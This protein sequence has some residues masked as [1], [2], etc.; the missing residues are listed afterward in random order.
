MSLNTLL[1]AVDC[2]S[3]WVGKTV[4]WLCLA[5]ILVLLYEVTSRYIAN[6]PTEWAHE[7][8]TM[9]YGTFCILGAVWTLRERGH[10]RTEVVYQVMSQKL[11]NFCDIVTGLV[12]LVMLVIFFYVAFEF[13]L[14]SWKSKEVSSKSTWGVIIY[15]F[16]TVIP[17]A[18]AL[19][20]LQQLSHMIR[21]VMRFIGRPTETLSVDTQD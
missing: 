18:V 7:S 3:E 11:Q 14:E 17:V 12:V 15:P 8:T 6:S 21:D 13:A 10:V 1:N 2:F 16:K 20:F 5:M 4:S 9:L 19:M